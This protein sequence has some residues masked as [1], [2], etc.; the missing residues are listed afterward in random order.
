VAELVADC[1]CYVPAVEHCK[2]FVVAFRTDGG[3]LR[4][5]MAGMQ[6]LG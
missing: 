4:D 5:I 3:N 6:Q 2:Y 1:R